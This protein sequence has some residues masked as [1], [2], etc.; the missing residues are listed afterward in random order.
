AEN[1]P[2]SEPAA[3]TPADGEQVEGSSVTL[4]WQ[5]GDPDGDAVVYDVYMERERPAPGL[6]QCHDAGSRSCDV[7]GL[8]AGETYYWQVAARDELGAKVLGPVWSFTVEPA[9]PLPDEITFVSEA[10]GD[11]DIYGM[12]ADGSGLTNLSNS[13][14]SDNGASWSPDGRRLVFHSDREGDNQLYV[15][16]ADGSDQQRLLASTAIDEWAYWSPAGDKIAFSRIA[17][18][19]DEGLLRTEVF[20]M[21]ADGTDV[22]R[23]TYTTGQTAQYTHGCWPSGWSPDGGEILYYCYDDGRHQIRI[24]NADG[25]NQRPIV[26]DGYWNSIP[27]M[28][29]DGTKVAFSSH[30]HG[31][32]DVYVINADG[33]GLQ[34]LTDDASDD[35][36][37]TW[38]GDGQKILFEANRDGITQ[39]Y[40]M[41]LDSSGQTR[42]TDN[43]SYAGQQSWRP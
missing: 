6:L 33:T 4:S 16:N 38:S 29:P 9:E 42:L 15:M 24:M 12:N 28:S 31:N 30:R 10:D 32:Y 8:Q 23:L 22:R 43:S 13:N 27:T 14:A 3:V 5:G 35:W 18:F 11:R 39:V 19:D 40:W 41:N 36:R 2:P 1:R 21:D 26:D 7:S 20:V 25:S 34:Q 37:P 17:D